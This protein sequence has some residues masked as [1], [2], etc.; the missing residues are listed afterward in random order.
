MVR[1]K[2]Q[3]KV[4]FLLGF[5]Q[6]KETEGIRAIKSLD[7]SGVSKGQIKRKGIFGSFHTG[8]PLNGAW[9]KTG[10]HSE[11]FKRC[12]SCVSS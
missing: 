9:S 12:T 6:V 7:S 8:R 3:G 1:E 5:G 4:R 10:Q 11:A 2:G